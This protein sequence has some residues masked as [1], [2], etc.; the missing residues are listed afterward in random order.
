METLFLTFAIFVV[1]VLAMSLG[2][3]LDNR[4]IKGSCGGLNDIPGVKCAA[5]T[6]QCEIK[7]AAVLG[8]SEQE[9][10]EPRDEEG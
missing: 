9:M 3:L 4:T 6:G 7:R 2:S 5:C 10:R 8:A 1:A